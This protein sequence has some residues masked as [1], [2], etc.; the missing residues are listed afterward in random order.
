MIVPIGE[1][2]SF[3]SAESSLENDEEDTILRLQIEV[4]KWVK[5]W[6]HR[7]F[8]LNTYT[9][10][11]DGEGT[12][13]IYLRQYPIISIIRIAIDIL[14]VVAVHN[15]ARTTSATVS[16]TE[17][18]VVLSKDEVD[19]SIPFSTYT[20]IG[21][22]ITAINTHGD[23]GWVASLQSADYADYQS[24]ELQPVFGLSCIWEQFAFLG[25][26]YYMAAGPYK[27]YPEEGLGY[28]HRDT[29]WPVGKRN[30]F[31]KYK[32]GYAS[33]AM[34]DDLKMA[35]KLIML[36]LYQAKEQGLFG[37]SSFSLGDL[38]MT[39]SKTE[40]GLMA[41]AEALNTLWSYRRLVY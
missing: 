24:T 14:D 32:A 39:F 12:H 9:E 18:G 38:S 6:C 22:V 4:E 31:V 37:V 3:L 11:Y 28:I 21:S 35:V 10:W 15:V 40:G 27:V 26:P 16:V 19:I 25:V 7:D 20:T 8:E 23:K 36:R 34:P 17:K 41:P 2:V 13:E 33:A 29:E 30:V 5:R 1:M